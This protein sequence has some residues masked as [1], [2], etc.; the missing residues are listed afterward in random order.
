MGDKTPKRPPKPKKPKPKPGPRR[1]R[2]G[3]MRWRPV[4]Q[5]R[6]FGR[7][8]VAGGLGL[9]SAGLLV[10]LHGVHA[11]VIVAAGPTAA[12]AI[13]FGCHLH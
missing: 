11:A 12:T 1:S 3:P 9:G 5:A 13:S 8:R 2:S 6:R 4:S 10:I 7:V